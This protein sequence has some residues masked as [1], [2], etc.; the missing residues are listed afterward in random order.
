M[1]KKKRRSILDVINPDGTKDND[2]FGDI[3]AEKFG[4]FLSN[5]IDNIRGKR[6]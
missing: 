2:G 1:S 4:K 3:L 6:R 5:V